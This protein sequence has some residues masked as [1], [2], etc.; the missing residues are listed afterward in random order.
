MQNLGLFRSPGETM[1]HSL[2]FL[3]H[4]RCHDFSIPIDACTVHYRGRSPVSIYRWLLIFARVP[5]REH[6]IA[7][8]PL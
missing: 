8:L 7:D 3:R 6:F 2:K 5:S 4:T 1:N